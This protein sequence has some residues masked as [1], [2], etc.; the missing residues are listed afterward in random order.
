M[1]NLTLGLAAAGGLGSTGEKEW[2]RKVL[3]VEAMVVVN[4]LSKLETS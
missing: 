4:W 3:M 1:Y 2:E